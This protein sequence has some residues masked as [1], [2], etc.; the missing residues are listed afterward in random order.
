MAGFGVNITLP[1]QEAAV[2]DQPWVDLQEILD[3]EPISRNGLAAALVR[4]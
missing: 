2:I 4:W 1:R 3:G